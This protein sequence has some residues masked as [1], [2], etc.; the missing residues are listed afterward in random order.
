MNPPSPTRPCSVAARPPTHAAD[1]PYASYY[2]G[3]VSVPT[4]AVLAQTDPYE[5][6]PTESQLNYDPYHQNHDPYQA[7]YNDSWNANGQ[8][9]P[10][11]QHHHH[12]RDHGANAYAEH[13]SY[14]GEHD[15][16]RYENHR[17]EQYPNHAPPRY[18]HSTTQHCNQDGG[19]NGGGYASRRTENCNDNGG[20]RWDEHSDAMAYDYEDNYDGLPTSFGS[21]KRKRDSTNRPHKKARSVEKYRRRKYNL[22]SKF[23]EGIKM[24]DVAWYSVTPEVIAQHHAER[25]RAALPPHALVVDAFLGGGGN[26]IQLALANLSV[27]A[28]ELCS[29]RLDIAKHNAGVYGVRHIDFILGNAYHLLPV[30][31]GVDAVL[32]SPP[33]GG[34]EYKCEGVFDVEQFRDLVRMA[35]ALTPNVAVLLPKNTDMEQ[36]VEVFGECEVEENYDEAGI[37]RMVTLYFGSLLQSITTVES[38]PT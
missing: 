5:Q 20:R 10:E 8:G 24:D 7:N 31:R 35:R 4:P 22:F 11:A 1:D 32:L 29:G 37:L 23:D 15:Q 19:D 13:E 38:G 34:P 36:I 18:H 3:G 25:F 30:L 16:H 26:A 12:Y 21:T 17:T 28:V 33:W 6:H 2:T 14:A 9:Y 27:L